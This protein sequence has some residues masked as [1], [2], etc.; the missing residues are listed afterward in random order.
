MKEDDLEK[1]FHSGISVLDIGDNQLGAQ[2]AFKYKEFIK[3]N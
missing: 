3:R 1:H 2:P